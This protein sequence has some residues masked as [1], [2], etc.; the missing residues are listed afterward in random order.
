MSGSIRYASL[1]TRREEVIICRFES[2][3]LDSIHWSIDREKGFVKYE[4]IEPVN[5][6]ADNN[7]IHPI[8]G[9]HELLK[10][11]ANRAINNNYRN[12]SAITSLS[13]ANLALYEAVLEAKSSM[14]Y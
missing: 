10:I 14:P 8:V 13:A 11:A 5:Q 2:Q 9:V 3:S 12:C 6:D 1:N 7:Y 4:L